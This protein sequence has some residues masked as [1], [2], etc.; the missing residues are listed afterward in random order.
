MRPREGFMESKLLSDL[1]SR[2]L[3]ALGD[4]IVIDLRSHLQSLNPLKDMTPLIEP[5]KEEEDERPTSA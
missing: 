4:R 3:V 5:A 2:L 1:I